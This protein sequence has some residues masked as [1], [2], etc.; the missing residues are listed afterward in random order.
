MDEEIE[1]GWLRLADKSELVVTTL[2][3]IQ[4]QDRGIFGESQTAVSRNAIA[5]VRVA[6]Q[7]SRWLVC[8][9]TILVLIYLVFTIGLMLASPANLP[10]MHGNLNLSSSTVLSIQYGALLGG[11]GLLLL[12]WFDK[13]AEIQIGAATG[14][15]GGTTKSYEEAQKFYSL[16]VSRRARP[17]ASKKSATE[18]AMEPKP[19]DRD[20]KL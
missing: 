11:V 18:V 9:G 15:V 1:L 14:S 12:F 6:W 5:T 13:Q 20:W 10:L 3:V 16:I 19:L 8:L 7:R 17:A 4:Y 2:H